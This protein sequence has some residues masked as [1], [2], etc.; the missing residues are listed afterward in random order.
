[1]VIAVSSQSG[2]LAGWR[3]D[4]WLAR[5]RRKALKTMRLQVTAIVAVPP[6]LLWI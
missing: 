2:F 3:D 1:M 4:L 6:G 5:A